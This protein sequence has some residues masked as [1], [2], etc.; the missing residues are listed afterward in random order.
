[1]R[2]T[3]EVEPNPVFN[4]V[5]IQIVPEAQTKAVLPPSV[6]EEIFATEYGKILNLRELQ[7]G[8][9]KINDWYSKNG[10]DLA[11]VIGSPQVTEDGTV[12]LTISE[13]LIEK[14]QVRYFTPEDEPAN[15]RTRSLSSPARCS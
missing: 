5:R 2:I 13:G 4:R 3:F 14:L 12:I 9:K 15:P 8:V 6:V 10:Y 7:N 11:Q 1:M